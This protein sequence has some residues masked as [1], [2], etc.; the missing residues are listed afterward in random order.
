M[1]YFHLTIIIFLLIFEILDVAADGAA[2]WRECCRRWTDV[3]YPHQGYGLGYLCVCWLCWLDIWVY[4]FNCVLLGLFF[5]NCDGGY[6][7]WWVFW[8]WNCDLFVIDECFLFFQ[9]WD[10]VMRWTL[11]EKMNWARRF[12]I[13]FVSVCSVMGRGL[14]GCCCS[15]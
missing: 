11:V 5:L 13:S 7:L 1:K 2:R 6:L 15:R 12:R 9:G 14:V 4:F 8:H 3:H 10:H